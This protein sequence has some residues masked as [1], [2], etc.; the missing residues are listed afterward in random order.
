MKNMKWMMGILVAV[1]AFAQA[2]NRAVDY[3]AE[4][5]AFSTV[6]ALRE[7]NVEAQ[8][9]AVL[10]LTGDRDG[11]SMLLRSELVRY[12]DYYE[13]Y[14]RDDAEWNKLLS[15]IE[16][17]DRRGDVMD[18][19]TIQKFGNVKGVDA[20][21]Y[22]SIREAT[23]EQNGDGLVRINLMLAD[24]ET[25]RQLWAG[26]IEGEYAQ[27]NAPDAKLQRAAIASAEAAAKEFANAKSRLGELD[28]LIFPLVKDR[29][30]FSD[31]V[32]TPFVNQSDS[33]I[34]FFKD[35]GLQ[36]GQRKVLDMVK[37]SKSDSAGIPDVLNL[38]SSLGAAGLIEDAAPV[39]EE[40]PKAVLIG[41][42]GAMTEDAL[43]ASLPLN[44]TLADAESGQV[45]WSANVE[46]VGMDVRGVGV[47]VLSKYGKQIAM[48]I[49]ILIVL[50]LLMKTMMRPR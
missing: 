47:S 23:A 46:P 20:I 24:V 18:P 37:G 15:E 19:S 16:F 50:G 30:D 17:G 29:T 28:I 8:R 35:L 32:S 34:R 36:K 43:T 31:I 5:A 22:G 27:L 44:L 14:V 11:L 21:L 3:A 42:F 33:S 4:D 1:A 13:F 26:M 10:P 41:R 45:L 25:G 39:A 48:G 7:S 12:S 2:A 6:V 40:R 49:G 9:I 38:L